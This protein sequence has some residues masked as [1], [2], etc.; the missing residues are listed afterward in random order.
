MA[1]YSE[2]DA[3][4]RKAHGFNVKTCWIAHSNFRGRPESKWRPENGAVS[5]QKAA[6]HP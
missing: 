1:T 3:Y 4:I 6:N 5:F 2:I